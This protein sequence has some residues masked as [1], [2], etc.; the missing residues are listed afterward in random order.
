VLDMQVAGA[1]TTERNAHNGI[2]RALQFGLRLV[3]QLKLAVGYVSVGEHCKSIYA[4]NLD[5]IA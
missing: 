2:T 4:P 1:N 5:Y 3:N